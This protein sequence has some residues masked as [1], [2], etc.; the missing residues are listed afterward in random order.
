MRTCEDALEASF[1]Y[2]SIFGLIVMI[3]RV[4]K[5]A[6]I[7]IKQGNEDDAHGIDQV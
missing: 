6:I 1:I 3:E 2:G 7:D 4:T 5:A